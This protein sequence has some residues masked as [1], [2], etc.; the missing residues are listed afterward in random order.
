MY[1]IFFASYLAML[2]LPLAGILYLYGQVTDMAEK[3]C[4]QHAMVA[5]SDTA[6]SLRAQLSWMDSAASRFLLDSQM[7]SM[8][9]AEPLS[10]GDKRV[11]SFKAFSEHLN[12]LI[13]TYDKDYLGFRMLFQ[14]SELVFYDDAISRG[15]EFFFNNALHYDGMTYSQW[16]E[17]VF[18]PDVRTLLPACDIHLGGTRV[19]AL[20]YNY[21]IV[22]RNATGSRKAVLQF[23]IQEEALHPASFNPLSTGYLLDA[24]GSVLA[25]FGARVPF[26]LTAAQLPGDTAWLRLEHGLMVMTEVRD[27]MQLAM[28]IPDEV[29]FRDVYAM[30][31]PM[32]MV[33][34]LC[35]AVEGLLMMYLAKRNARPIEHMASDMTQVLDAPRQGNE[36]E[37]IHQGIL[38]LKQN[39]HNAEQHSVQMETALLLNHLMN[40]RIDDVET[41]LKDGERIGI[42]LRAAGYCAVLA[43]LPAGAAPAHDAVIPALP[44]HMRVVTG[45]GRRNRL[46]VLYLLDTQEAVENAA[47][48]PAHMRQLL[49][50]LPEGTRMGQGRLCTALDD[51]TFS[52]SQ[53]LYCLKTDNA[54][55]SILS[56]DQVSPGV[57]SLYF[58]L[59]QQQRIINAVKH[60]NTAVID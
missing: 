19:R 10:Y 48:I 6:V 27:G 40:Q 44:P 60:N 16:Y 49:A 58:P 45:E 28:L 13:G 51:V 9:Y 53:A 31:W 29:A 59:E 14:D 35:A 41:L 24:D 21:P 17:A 20:T 23:F 52:F 11:N 3:N 8:M 57:N 38:Q 42:D 56:F 22:R 15:L 47:A 46:K 32:M 5:I 54:E 18:F 12:D 30:R 36:L 2:L 7:T 25:D 37:T 50:Q 55:G 1:L 26:P 39:Q 4:V 43:Q 34:L 33:F